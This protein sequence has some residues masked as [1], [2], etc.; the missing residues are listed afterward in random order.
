MADQLHAGPEA[1]RIEIP[2]SSVGGFEVSTERV[3]E[4]LPT[5]NELRIEPLPETVSPVQAHTSVPTKAVRMVSPMHR[6]IEK[7]LEEDLLPLYRELNSEQRMQFRVAGEE[8]AGKIERLLSKAVVRARDVIKVLKDWL[9][10]LPGVNRFFI[11]QEAKIKA[12]K[13]L[14]LK[15]ITPS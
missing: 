5:D 1:P 15:T 3:V 6:Q 2:P 4:S 13:I 8:A 9:S 14:F 10:L 11:E 7:V 12:D